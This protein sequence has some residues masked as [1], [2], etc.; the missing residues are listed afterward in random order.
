[1]PNYLIK[2]ERLGL[3]NWKESDLEPFAEICSD[4]LVME[5]FTKSLNKEETHQL[6]IRLQ[7]HF[8]E[9]GF[10]YFAVD[11]LDLDEFIGFIGL[12]H[13][14]YKNHFAPCVDIGWRLS[15]N[16]WG[17]G[18]ATEG[19]RACLDFAF[20][21]LNLKEIFALC[22]EINLKSQHV[23]RKIGMQFHSKFE[24]PK[25]EIDNPLRP[26]VVYNI[27]KGNL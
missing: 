13:L 4:K 27:K 26:M 20:N 24:H 8:E 11:R 22:S 7:Q 21:E 1:M 17:N 10:C 25:I 19:A 12:F 15:R 3:R 5:F 14:T 9:H 23:M 6:I 16:A 2:T 18:F